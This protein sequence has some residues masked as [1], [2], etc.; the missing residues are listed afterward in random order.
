MNFSYMYNSMN[1]CRGDDFSDKLTSDS[2]LFLQ[3]AA[4]KG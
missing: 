3:I 1:I 2:L 4:V